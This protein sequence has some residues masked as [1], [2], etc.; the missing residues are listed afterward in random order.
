MKFEFTRLSNDCM[1]P[2]GQVLGLR[3]NASSIVDTYLKQEPLGRNG[4]VK[5]W[6]LYKADMV[7]SEKA[8]NDYY[9]P[10]VFVGLFD[11]SAKGADQDAQFRFHLD[12]KRV[13][14]YAVLRPAD[15]VA[16][17]PKVPLYDDGF[18]DEPLDNTDLDD[19]YSFDGAE[20][21]VC[22]VFNS[23][24]N[25]EALKYI[26]NDPVHGKKLY[27]KTVSFLSHYHFDIHIYIY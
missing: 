24:S 6:E 11:K 4:G 3:S 8:R 17:P 1:N 26:A 12:S 23:K 27:K 10:Y 7:V 15:E 25:A 19:M 9:D 18:G 20:A 21:G 2:S 16:R 22:I 13:C 14:M 5:A